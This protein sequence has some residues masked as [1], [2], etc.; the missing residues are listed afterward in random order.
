MNAD[1][2]LTIVSV[3]VAI[4]AV[5]VTLDYWALILV[6][7]R[8]L[9]GFMNSESDPVQRMVLLVAAIGLL[10]VANRLDVIPIVGGYVNSII[11]NIAIAI[12]SMV[13]ANFIMAMADLVKAAIGN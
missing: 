5:F 8:F 2:I 6:W 13:I 9:P 7:L 3:L 11:D 1:K 4:L 12:S 10:V